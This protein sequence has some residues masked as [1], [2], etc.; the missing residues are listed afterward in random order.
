MTVELL[1]NAWHNFKALTDISPCSPLSE[2]VDEEGIHSLQGIRD[3]AQRWLTGV[4][5]RE[6]AEL[7]LDKACTC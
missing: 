7:A 4:M 3:P 6:A 1:A 5:C 2:A